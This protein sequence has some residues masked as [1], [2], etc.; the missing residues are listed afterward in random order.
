MDIIP[1]TI[2]PLTNLSDVFVD[3]IPF[4]KRLKEIMDRPSG[5]TLKIRVPL[6]CGSHNPCPSAENSY[7]LSNSSGKKRYTNSLTD[8]EMKGIIGTRR[9]LNFQSPM[10]TIEV[11]QD[12]REMKRTLKESLGLPSRIQRGSPLV[13]KYRSTILQTKSPDSIQTFKLPTISQQKVKFDSRKRTP[14]PTRKLPYNIKINALSTSKVVQAKP[15]HLVTYNDNSLHLDGYND[16]TN[17]L[18]AEN[19]SKFIICYLK[20]LDK[21]VK[22][23]I[24]QIKKAPYGKQ[25]VNMEGIRQFFWTTDLAYYGFAT[26]DVIQKYVKSWEDAHTIYQKV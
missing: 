24:E 17:T 7:Y 5:P 3:D 10:Q 22:E 9:S 23:R 11:G 14:V 1:E 12:I 25:L 21:Q 4:L 2:R 15:D 13:E 20:Q 8:S 26:K 18:N 6:K 19:Y 16:A